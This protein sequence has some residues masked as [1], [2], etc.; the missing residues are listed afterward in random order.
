MLLSKLARCDLH[1]ED[2]HRAKNFS[3]PAFGRD[4][5]F[6][7]TNCELGKLPDNLRGRSAEV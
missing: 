4:R 7:N 2:M 6:G 1:R 3:S 5:D